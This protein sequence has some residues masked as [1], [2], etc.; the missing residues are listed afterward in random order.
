[1]D[2]TIAGKDL[3]RIRANPTLKVRLTPRSWT[4]T[5]S[6]DP[7][8]RTGSALPVPSFGRSL[9][10]N[11]GCRWLRAV[12]GEEG[13]PGVPPL[14]LRCRGALAAR[15]LVRLRLPCRPPACRAD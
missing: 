14:A 9:A 13:R 1:M 2:R 11:D 12:A 8:A 5:A 7:F 10:G 4:P 15:R 3:F 6:D